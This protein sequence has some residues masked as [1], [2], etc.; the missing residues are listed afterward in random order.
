VT[1]VQTTIH[2]AAEPAALAEIAKRLLRA[3][4]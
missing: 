1:Q 4:L 2:L 3:T